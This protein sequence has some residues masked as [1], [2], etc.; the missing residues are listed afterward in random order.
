MNINKYIFIPETKYDP[1]LSVKC[2]GFNVDIRRLLVFVIGIP[3]RPF[4]ISRG[5][6]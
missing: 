4:N 1:V 2:D 5:L 3:D 6:R